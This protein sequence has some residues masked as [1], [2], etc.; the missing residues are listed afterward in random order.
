MSPNSHSSSSSKWIAIRNGPRPT[1]YGTLRVGI[2]L[3]A[4][5]VERQHQSPQISLATILR[6]PPRIHIAIHL[7]CFHAVTLGTREPRVVEASPTLRFGSATSV[8]LRDREMSHAK[9]LRH[10]VPPVPPLPL[11]A[12]AQD[13][14]HTACLL[15]ASH[16]GRSEP[17]RVP[18]T[19][20]QTMMLSSSTHTALGSPTDDQKGYRREGDGRTDAPRKDSQSEDGQVGLLADGTRVSEL[21]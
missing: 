8:S 18:S 3:K 15:T 12:P 2:W 11:V 14:G 16:R 5:A 9:T 13:T 6:G 20:S 1:A 21:A 7:C 4:S 10:C 19:S 17:I